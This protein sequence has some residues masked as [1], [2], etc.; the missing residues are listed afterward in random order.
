[1]VKLFVYKSVK[2]EVDNVEWLNKNSQ[3]IIFIK[4]NV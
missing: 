1:M 3:I 4:R 2:C